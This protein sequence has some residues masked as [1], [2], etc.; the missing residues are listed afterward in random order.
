MGAVLVADRG[1]NSP[2]VRMNIKTIWFA[3]VLLLA[4]SI[5]WAGTYK[6]K[7]N[8]AEGVPQ[9]VERLDAEHGQLDRLLE[10]R[11]RVERWQAKLDKEKKRLGAELNAARRDREKVQAGEMTENQLAEKWYNSGR[12]M[13][14]HDEVK[15]FKAEAARLNAYIGKYNALAQ[16]LS[17]YLE[18]RSPGEV[19][20]LME[21]MYELSEI[22]KE[23][24]NEGNYVRAQYIAQHS[25]LASQFGYETQ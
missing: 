10:M 25:E 5:A 21:E 18:G 3:G 12:S 19:G 8:D 22:L 15:E 17:A 9:L 4:T 20:E 7:P 11:A 14:N 24:L 13:R 16:D 23:A 1:A 2:E 6:G